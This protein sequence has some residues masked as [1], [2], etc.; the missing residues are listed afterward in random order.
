MV[1]C[2]FIGAFV[3]FS[4]RTLGTGISWIPPR[5]HVGR[6]VD[7]QLETGNH[8]QF[9]SQTPQL[10]TAG[11]I[12]IDGCSINGQSAKPPPILCGL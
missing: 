11:R 4:S 7:E 3:E 1:G 10:V 5:I 12:T 8:S 9:C 2:L 6:Y